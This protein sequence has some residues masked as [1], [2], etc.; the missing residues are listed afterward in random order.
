MSDRKALIRLAATLPKGSDDRRTL[1]GLAQKQASPMD[2]VS[3]FDIEREMID[4]V[5]NAIDD[6]EMEYDS[7]GTDTHTKP[8][9]GFTFGSG[10]DAGVGGATYTDLGSIAGAGRWPN[11]SKLSGPLL[12]AEEKAHDYALGQ[13]MKDNAAFIQENGLTKDQINYNDLY[14]MDF[15]AEAESLDEYHRAAMEEEQTTFRVGA[16]YFD[17]ENDKVGRGKHAME[18]FARVDFDGHFLPRSIETFSTDFTFSDMKDLE[19][20]L[21]AALSAAVKSLA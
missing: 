21:K 9:R 5:E 18:V 8:G 16:F 1:L 2:G 10:T 3:L 14:E 11:N 17:D 20:K 6:V 19:K 7:Y 12:K 4:Q 15:G 13:W